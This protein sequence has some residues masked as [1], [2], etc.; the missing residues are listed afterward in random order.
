[1]PCS[2]SA[3][4]VQSS[5]KFKG[6]AWIACFT[7]SA[8]L[9]GGGPTTASRDRNPGLISSHAKNPQTSGVTGASVQ[10][11]VQVSDSMRS[12][13]FDVDRFLTL[14][15]GFTI[16]VYAR[17][18]G[19]RFMAVAPNGD[20]LVSQP[21]SGSV[22]LLRATGDGDPTIHTFVSG[23]KR[24]H[25]IVFHSIDGVTYVYISETNQID[26]F[27]YNS[28]DTFA[29]DRQVIVTGLPDSSSPELHGAYGHELKNIAL[30]AGHR[31]YV[32]IGSTCNVCTAD[33]ISWPLRAAIY[34]YDADGSNARLFARGLRN[35][36]G[37][38]FLPGAGDLWVVVNGRDE[39]A[40]PSKDSTGQYGR[41]VPAYVDDHPPDEFTQVREGGN[42]G[43]PFCN[44]NPDTSSTMDTMPFDPDYQLNAG[45]QV[46]CG[47]M[48]RISKGIQAHSAPLGLLFLQETAF[49]EGYRDGAVVA[50]H[51][52]WDRQKKTGYKVIYF[53]WDGASGNPGPQMDMVTGWLDDASQQ[54]WGRPV[55]IAVDQQGNLF[56][57]DDYS[58][59]IYEVSPVRA[60][61]AITAAFAQGR[62]VVVV[63]DNFDAGAVIQLNGQPV[64]TRHDDT[65]PNRLIAKRLL[66]HI[67]HGQTVNLQVRNSDGGLSAAFS[68]TRP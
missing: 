46:D 66:K 10:V 52:S 24:P 45:N 14:P 12:S 48:D 37:L 47:S 34:Q 20:L 67:D 1:M 32:S 40:Y 65:N 54:V 19:A 41:V 62:S 17:I 59:T 8:Y 13:P 56:V 16:S 68:F 42:Y 27:L 49:S 58:G 9:I 33:T 18:G 28:G 30:D 11:K 39:I 2:R 50:L 55:G 36:E 44:P 7:I 35:A 21:G 4:I 60:S 5:F 29:H 51:G 43:W 25:G 63:G 6:L 38:A 61:P 31:L 15:P 57:S 26:R 22:L 64:V 3:Y 53:P 23:L